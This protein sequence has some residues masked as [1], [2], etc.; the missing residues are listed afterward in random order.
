MNPER[1][2]YEVTAD[3]FTGLVR[4]RNEDSF[5]YAW[6]ES[7]KNLLAAV[8]DGIGSTRNGDIASDSVLRMLVQA[9]RKL[10][11]SG[12]NRNQC[13][14]F[15]NF[16]CRQFHEINR[17]LYE[18]NMVTADVQKQKS[19]GTTL[20]CAVFQNNAMVAVNAG[21]TP[22][23][24]IRDGE[25][26]QLTFDHNLTNELIRSGQLSRMEAESLPQGRMLTRFIGPMNSVEPECYYSDVRKG[27]SF[28]LCSDGLT[29]HVK[30]EEICEIVTGEENISEAVKILFRRTLYRGASDNATLILVR[31]V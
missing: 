9:W 15:R 11:P 28:L 8:A 21:D 16:L 30:P 1:N 7:G 22:L 24:R 25:I 29:Y 10:K 2:P 31:A 17:R 12:S 14:V 13:G 4:S 3:S 19:L 6:D 27:D 20:T 26:R 18:I 23:F 5:A